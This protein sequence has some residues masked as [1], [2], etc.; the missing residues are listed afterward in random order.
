MGKKRK[1]RDVETI[2]PELSLRHGFDP[3]GLLGHENTYA[4]NVTEHVAV[5]VDTVFACVRLLQAAVG[6]ADVGEY[7]GNERLPDSRLTRRPMG[8][9]TR[10]TWIKRAVSIMALYNG[11]YLVRSPFR[12]SE[13]VTLSVEPVPPSRIQ[14][15]DRRTVR[16]DGERIDPDR[17]IWVPRMELPTIT[18]ELGWTIRLARESIASAWAS[19]QYGSDFWESGGSPSWYLSTE[20]SLSRQDAIDIR[21]SVAEQRAANPGKPLVVGKG[22]KPGTIG[23][24]LASTGASEATARL[25]ARIARYFGVHAYLVNVMSEA[26]NLVYQNAAAAGLD[27]VRFTLQPDYAGP[28]ADALTDELPGNAIDGRRVIFGLRHL[29]RGTNLEEAQ[30]YQIA[31]GSKPWMIP[32]EVRNDLHMPMDTTLDEAGAPA[33]ALERIDA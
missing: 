17:L 12:D 8:S 32:S 2:E 3:G 25:G 9:I 33:P 6:D 19:D 24:D 14:W 31:T 15:E 7:R 21:D 10:R 13:G 18:R 27:L 11:T 20:A 22:A 4:V 1:A 29:T 26:G 23:A 28:L 5:A 30:T 16:M